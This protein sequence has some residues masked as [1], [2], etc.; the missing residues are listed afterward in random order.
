MANSYYD[1]TDYTLLD[2]ETPA[3]KAEKLVVEQGIGVCQKCGK[4]IGKGIAIH[5]RSCVGHPEQAA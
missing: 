3:Q 1:D 4:H 5:S 2:F